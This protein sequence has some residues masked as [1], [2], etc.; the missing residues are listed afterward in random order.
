M[1]KHEFYENLFENNLQ[2]SSKPTRKKANKGNRNFKPCE[3]MLDRLNNTAC[4]MF[5]FDLYIKLF[6]TLIIGKDMGQSQS[7]RNNRSNQCN[8]NNR[9]YK[10]HTSSYSGKGTKADLKNHS[11]Q[12]NPNNKRYK[13]RKK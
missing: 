8:P 3:E 9:R 10:G 11:N 2:Q 4:P 7:N 12:L 5:T 6:H 13:A 1:T